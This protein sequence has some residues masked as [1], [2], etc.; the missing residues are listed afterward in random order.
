VDQDDRVA[1]AD[2]SPDDGLAV[3]VKRVIKRQ[4]VATLHETCYNAFSGYL[5]DHRKATVFLIINGYR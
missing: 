1:L 3:V 4:H 2:A 5:V